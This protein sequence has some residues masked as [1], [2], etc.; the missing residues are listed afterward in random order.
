MDLYATKT[1]AGNQLSQ[2]V[3]AVTADAVSSISDHSLPF[4]QHH[5][6][7]ADNKT[8]FYF[9]LPADGLSGPAIR[10]KAPAV[11]RRYGQRLDQALG[12][13]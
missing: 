2:L 11:W 7:G 5:L 6:P 1:R 3:R 4:A 10:L 13:W 8:V 12:R 9:P